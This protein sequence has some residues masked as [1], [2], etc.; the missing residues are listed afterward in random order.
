MLSL[1]LLA[2]AAIPLL[3]NV[4]DEEATDDGGKS[5]EDALVW[6]L[7]EDEE[8]VILRLVPCLLVETGVVAVKEWLFGVNV[9]M[10]E[11]MV[12]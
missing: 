9:D 5:V 3:V 2:A 12:G 4:T 10:V 1:S 11:H 7:S 6:R 8:D